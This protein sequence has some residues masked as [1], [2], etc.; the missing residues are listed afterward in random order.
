MLNLERVKIQH[1]NPEKRVKSFDIEP[2]RE[3]TDQEA[4][5][6]AGR[7]IGCNICTQSCPASLDIG[8]YIRSTAVGDPADTVR[9]VFENLPFP[10]IIGRV[11]TH[12]CEDICVLYD[13][14]GPIAIRHLKRYAADKFQDYS[15][16]LDLPKR[17]F[18]NKKVAIVGGGPA[19]LT[20]AYYL[21]I[22]GVQVTLYEALPVLGGFMRTGIPRYRLPDE[23]IDKE[24]N[25]ILSLGVEV[26]TNARI[27]KDVKFADLMKNYDAVFIGVGNHKPR[28][29]GT[30]GSDAKGIY[31]ATEFL[32]RVNLGERIDV[33][34]NVVV[35]GGGFTANDSS[36]VSLRLG[37]ENVYIMYRRREI[38]R[39]GYPSLNAEEEMEESVEEKVQYIWE[40]TPFE[41][42]AENG[43]VI[44]VKYW[45]NEMVT[46]GHGRAKPVPQKDKVRYI[47]ADTV[48]EATGQETDF[49]FMDDEYLKR[50][51]LTPAGHIIT[52]PQG[53]T[54]IPGLF[55]GG[56]STNTARDLISAV[57]DADTAVI[58]ILEYLNV[59]DQIADDRWLPYLDRWKKYTPN[60]VQR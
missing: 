38:D 32:Q 47:Q 30:P 2:L 59:M 26:K 10:A 50:L 23:V 58:G 40:V 11:C 53:M 54:S 56:D 13:T 19:G 29:T 14:G 41:Y 12:M 5:A 57:R 48:I 52:N 7:C 49:S 3:Y 8:G 17:N 45:E 15:K 51:R 39:P 33:G 4:Y 55:S 37:A 24:I 43:R 16:I 34:K 35:I 22:Q 60:L 21:A 31:H 28:M 1:E 44:G 36:R 27:G 42:V 9:I 25:F 20:A 46:E 6:E 18:I